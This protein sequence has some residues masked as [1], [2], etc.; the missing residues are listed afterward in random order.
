VVVAVVV[1]E[2]VEATEEDGPETTEADGKVDMDRLEEGHQEDRPEEGH[3]EDRLEEGH[4]EEDHQEEDHQEEAPEEETLRYEGSISILS[5]K[6]S[7]SQNSTDPTRSSKR[8]PTRAIVTGS[9]ARR[10]HC[11]EYSLRR[12]LL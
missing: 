8:G 12:R 4:L 3:Q 6:R 2:E 7:K 9:L 10:N 11:F 1:E 5:S